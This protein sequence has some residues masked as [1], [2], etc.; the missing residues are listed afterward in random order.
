MGDKC[1][2]CGHWTTSGKQAYHEQHKAIFGVDL[3]RPISELIEGFRKS[4][5]NTR[6]Q[7]WDIGFRYTGWTERFAPIEGLLTCALVYLAYIGDEAKEH[8][9][10]YGNRSTTDAATPATPE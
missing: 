6:G 7:M 2:K 8:E 1:D 9:A 4:L 3:S 10:K 5:A